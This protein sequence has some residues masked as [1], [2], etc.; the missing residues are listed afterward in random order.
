[1]SAS[2]GTPEYSCGDMVAGD[3][4]LPRSRPSRRRNNGAVQQPDVGQLEEITRLGSRQPRKPKLTLAPGM[5]SS[6]KRRTAPTQAIGTPPLI[7]GLARP[8]NVSQP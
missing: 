8:Q 4:W 7:W 2:S 6:N 5:S 3:S 1:M